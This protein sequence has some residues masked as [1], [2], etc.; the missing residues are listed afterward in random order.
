MRCLCS[1]SRLEPMF[2]W[3]CMHKLHDKGWVCPIPLSVSVPRKWPRIVLAMYIF[4]LIQQT[5]TFPAQQKKRCLRAMGLQ[6]HFLT[7]KRCHGKRGESYFSEAP[8]ETMT[9]HAEE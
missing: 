3:C 4:V 5:I 6:N 2:K 1:F 8:S 7:F 9:T